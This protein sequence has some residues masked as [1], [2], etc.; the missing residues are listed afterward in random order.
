[1]ETSTQSATGTVTVAGYSHVNLAVDDLDAA[2]A[3]YCDALGFTVLPRPDFEGPAGAW[4]GHS[5]A[6]VHLSVVDKMPPRTTF[7]H[8]AFHIPT[9]A[10]ADT[11]DALRARGVKF[12]FEPSSRQDFGVTIWAAFIEDPSGNL[13]E[14]TDVDPG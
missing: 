8:I 3:F 14:L 6:Q 5:S 11:M 1:M 9:D 10:Y 4:L 2:V 13:I 7:A 12:Y